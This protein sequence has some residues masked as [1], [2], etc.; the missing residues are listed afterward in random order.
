MEA[1]PKQSESNA[2][3]KQKGVRKSLK[4]SKKNKFE[5]WSV[6]SNYK[7][8]KLLGEGSYGQVA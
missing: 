1:K 4:F 8:E 5:G 7:L 3:D 6:G 2:E